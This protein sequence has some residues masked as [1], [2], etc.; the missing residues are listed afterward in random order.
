MRH[1]NN[2]KNTTQII[3][4]YAMEYLIDDDM[5]KAAFLTY[6]KDSV[7]I[8]FENVFETFKTLLGISYTV[9]DDFKPILNQLVQT[10]SNNCLT[11]RQMKSLFHT[12]Y[13][14]TGSEDIFESQNLVEEAFVT[15]DPDG[16][17]SIPMND[18]DEIKSKI[19]EKFRIIQPE[20][21][22]QFGIQ[23]EDI[24]NEISG[25]A[26]FKGDHVDYKLFIQNVIF[27]LKKLFV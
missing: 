20:L 21:E 22:T 7:R 11:L 9:E 3:F 17:G 12:I 10:D 19:K 4:Y 25:I 5:I 23:E 27:K 24:E 2:K 1:Q 15:I 16:D 14:I 18:M 26:D 8:P 6:S 13:I